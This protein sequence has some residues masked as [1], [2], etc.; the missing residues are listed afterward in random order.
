MTRSESAIIWERLALEASRSS[1][2]PSRS[3]W[4][5]SGGER[6]LGWEDGKEGGRKRVGLGGQ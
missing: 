3:H 5:L 2:S 4:R 1:S 6:E